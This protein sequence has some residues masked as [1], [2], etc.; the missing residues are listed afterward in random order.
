[1]VIFHNYVELPQG[2]QSHFMVKMTAGLLSLS[3]FVIPSDMNTPA[4]SPKYCVRKSS[5]TP[6]FLARVLWSLG[7]MI[8]VPLPTLQSSD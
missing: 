5:M 6:W 4:M 2:T 1:M 3:L 7:M 8:C